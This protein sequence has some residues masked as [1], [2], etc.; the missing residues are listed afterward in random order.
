MNSI[1][2]EARKRPA[3][4]LRLGKVLERRGVQREAQHASKLEQSQN[5]AYTWRKKSASISPR[6]AVRV[7]C[8][9]YHIS[10]FRVDESYLFTTQ[11]L[12]M[13]YTQYL[14]KNIIHNHIKAGRSGSAFVFHSG[15][16]K[17][18][19]FLFSSVYL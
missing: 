12:Y 2:Q 6:K 14:L 15:N 3:V 5:H 10:F 8:D 19:C 11:K 4:L 16:T 13:S 9:C 18:V 7:K 1:T 17:I